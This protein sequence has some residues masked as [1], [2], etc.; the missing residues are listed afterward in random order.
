MQVGDRATV[1]FICHLCTLVVTRLGLRFVDFVALR[2]TAN[3]RRY[4]WLALT[5]SWRVRCGRRRLPRG[6]VDRQLVGEV[7]E[8]AHV[9]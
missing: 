5:R 9:R 4:L 3:W 1:R 2:L 6:E 7:T 8:I